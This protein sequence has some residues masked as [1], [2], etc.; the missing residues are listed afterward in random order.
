MKVASNNLFYLLEKFYIFRRSVA[1][2]FNLISF[3]CNEKRLN[4]IPNSNS[5][6]NELDPQ[7]CFACLIVG[8]QPTCLQLLPH[9]LVGPRTFSAHLS[10]TTSHSTHA[11]A[12]SVSVAWARAPLWPTRRQVP[13]YA[14]PARQ[15]LLSLIVVAPPLH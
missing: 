6:L 14:G 11:D 7:A 10:A 13:L 3:L 8:P 1:I 2:S 12:L 15:G 4:Q 5:F 9:Y